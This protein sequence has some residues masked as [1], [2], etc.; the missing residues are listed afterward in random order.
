[1]QLILF[2]ISMKKRIA[3]ITSVVMIAT[4]FIAGTYYVAIFLP[5]KQKAEIEKVKSEL[6]TK[7]EQASTEQA[8][9]NQENKKLEEEKKMLDDAEQQ[10]NEDDA[11]QA[12]ELKAQQSKQRSAS[13]KKCLDTVE[14]YYQKKYDDLESDINKYGYTDTFAIAMLNWKNN[15]TENINACHK[16]YD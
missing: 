15:K 1:M 8:K 12:E 2:F 16:K 10:K 7:L 9:I 11:R 3:L 6:E 14:A 4:L 5:K 13:L